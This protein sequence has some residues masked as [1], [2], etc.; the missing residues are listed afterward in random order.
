MKTWDIG[1]G[2]GGGG[3]EQKMNMHV[4]A[5]PKLW[6]RMC[7]TE[8]TVN[9]RNTLMWGDSLFADFSTVFATLPLCSLTC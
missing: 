1:G 9:A 3:V 6:V 5:M 4:E 2:G 8:T 7:V